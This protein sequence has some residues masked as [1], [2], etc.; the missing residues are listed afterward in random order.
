MTYK[1]DTPIKHT[2]PP[3]IHNFVS[4]NCPYYCLIIVRPVHVGSRDILPLNSHEMLQ[5][6]Y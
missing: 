2:Y 6:K 3:N 4:E 5:Y 1:W